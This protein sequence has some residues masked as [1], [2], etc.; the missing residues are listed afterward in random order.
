MN[1]IKAAARAG[2]T[3]ALAQLMNQSFQ[4]KG[5]RVQVVRSGAVLKVLMESDRLPDRKL[6]GAMRKGIDGIR[7]AGVEKVFLKA[8]AS[9]GEDS[10]IEQWALGGPQPVAKTSA[11]N[12]SQKAASEV[13]TEPQSG[14]GCGKIFV[15]GLLAIL[16]VLLG[17]GFLVY[18]GT[19]SR[20]EERFAGATEEQPEEPAP[21]VDPFAKGI[22]YA[23][24]AANSAQNAQL[25]SEWKR[26]SNLWEAAIGQM[27]AVPE[28]SPNKALSQ[29]KAT[30]Y[31]K[32]RQ[33]AAGRVAT[34]EAQR[35]QQEAQAEAQ[36][37]IIF[38]E[39]VASADPNGALIASINLSSYSKDAL[40]IVVQ[41]DWYTLPEGTQAD[42]AVSLRNVWQQQCNCQTPILIFYSSAGRKLVSISVGQ[43]RFEK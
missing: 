33:Y 9:G 26:T 13:K 1:D 2:D 18:N 14:S 19:W 42:I 11:A 22:E 34:L 8:Q 27:N 39:A 7:P 5:I 4:P 31:E 20:I 35:L 23:T 36:R 12:S 37:L 32:N 30:E 24:S 6:A 40:D 43:P 41:Q 38:K 3:K 28:G 17:R 15:W 10:W 25:E 16:A 29:Q 21:P